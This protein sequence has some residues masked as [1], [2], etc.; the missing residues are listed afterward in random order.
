MRTISGEEW[1]G[2][3]QRWMAF[4]FQD[5]FIWFTFGYVGSLWRVWAFSSRENRGYPLVA[6]RERLVEVASPV[7]TH[8][9]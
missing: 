2:D 3:G 7:G 5:L 6:A 9:L 8:G 1:T 4:L